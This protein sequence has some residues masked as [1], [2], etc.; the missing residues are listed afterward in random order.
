MNKKHSFDRQ[1]RVLFW[2]CI[3]IAIVMFLA[4]AG[5]FFR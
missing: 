5:R 2:V 1:E 3:V 4:F